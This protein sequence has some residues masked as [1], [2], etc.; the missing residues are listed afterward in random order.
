MKE[1]QKYLKPL[2]TVTMFTPYVEGMLEAQVYTAI[3]EG[4]NVVKKLITYNN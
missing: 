2:E 4:D 1:K 3:F